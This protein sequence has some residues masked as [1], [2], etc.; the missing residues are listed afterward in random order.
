M[1]WARCETEGTCSDVHAPGG[2]GRCLRHLTPDERRSVFQGWAGRGRGEVADVRGTVFDS[3]LVTDF[4]RR[5][6]TELPG[7]WH[8]RGC[9]LI[10][11]A[12]FGGVQFAGDVDFGLVVFEDVAVFDETAFYSPVF[13]DQAKFAWSKWIAPCFEPEGRTGRHMPARSGPIPL[14]WPLTSPDRRPVEV[15][16]RSSDNDVDEP[17]D[18]LEAV[19]DRVVTSPQPWRPRPTLPFST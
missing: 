6:S 14:R 8:F 12:D 11:R 1:T 16:R 2:G 13:F 5:Q 4:F 7:S 17:L 19:L 3:A 15:V 18:I 9:R 10:G